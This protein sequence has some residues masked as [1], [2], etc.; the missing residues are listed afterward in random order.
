MLSDPISDMLTRIK[1][2]YMAKKHEVLV[3]ASKTK[4]AIANI[5]KNTGFIGNVKERVKETDGKKEME[6]KEII[7]TLIYRNDIPALKMIKRVSKPG[8]RIYKGAKEMPN[9]LN[10]YGVAIVSTSKGIMTNKE[11]RKQN[12]G[13]EIICEL[14]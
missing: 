1:N 2:A 7:V 4:L 12:I 8:R 14:Y 9:V 11:A 5:L 10:G 13:G 3:P 6:K